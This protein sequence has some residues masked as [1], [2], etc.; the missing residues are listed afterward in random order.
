ME[1]R[2]IGQR[3]IERLN[4]PKQGSRIEYDKEIPGFGIRVTGAGVKSFVLNYH[5]NGRERR[6]TIGR[7]PEW[8][9][10][11]AREE[12]LDLRK[13]INT[14]KDPL[15]ER[16]LKRAEGTVAE[17]AKDYLERHA[18]P[19]KRQSS[20]R[21]DRQ[22]LNN[23]ILPRL[24]KLKVSAVGR[25]DIESLHHSFKATPYRANRVLSLLSTMFF[26]AGKWGMRA[27]NP[28]KGIPR[29]HEDRRETWLTA[30]Q[31]EKL[32][33]ALNSYPQQEAA[34]VLRLLILT[35]SREGEVLGA[36]W[37]QFDL[38]RG[39]WTKPSHHTKQKKI[40]HV[41]LS[42]AA[43]LVLTPM[44]EQKTSPYLFPGKAKGTA[45]ARVSIRRPWVQVCKAADLAAEVR[46]PG[47]RK[48][49]IRYKP[50]I[51][52]HD[53]RHTYASHLVS[54]GT[55]LH[56]VGK[57]LGHTQA[58]TTQRYAHVAD[59]ALRSATN[60]FGKMMSAGVR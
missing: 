13:E 41:P 26:L 19:H 14:G 46:I 51:R 37:D 12:A 11:A 6:I 20:L 39:I 18:I 54:R 43:L 4:P 23:I 3:M 21:N 55:S 30:E 16:E 59:E 45:K 29:F 15:H 24:G 35:G 8:S 34:N 7:W 48:E 52:I 60:D 1:K 49:L 53:L 2:K 22:M 40:E 47:K 28:T 32:E 44:A 36:T 5:V 27:D 42:K 31:L 33:A 38:Q 10:D 50:T 57:L 56:I 58:Q 9:A 17:L 25:R